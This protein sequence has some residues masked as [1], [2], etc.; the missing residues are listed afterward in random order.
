MTRKTAPTLL[1]LL[2]IPL[3]GWAQVDTSEWLCESCPF[4]DGHRGNYDVG[5]TYVSDDAVRYGNATGYDSEGFYANIDGDG[6][7]SSDGYRANWRIEDLGLDSRVLSMDTGR[8]GVY[9]L[10]LGYSELPYRRFDSTQTIFK[11]SSGVLEL[12]PSWVAAGT[13]GGFTELATS[14]KSQNIESDRQLAEIGGHWF[15]TNAIRVY[16]DYSRQTRDGI[17]I[18]GGPGFSQ[19]ALLPRRIDFATD[20]MDVGIRYLGKNGSLTLA[21]FGS[22]FDNR[23]S[24][25]TWQTPF[26]AAPGAEQLTMAEE[27]DNSY[28]QLSLS[29]AWHADF[30]NTVLA[31]SLAQGQGEQNDALL[32]Y[33][34]N[35]NVV[36][37]ALPVNSLRGQVDT[38]NYAVSIT[39]HPIQRARIRFS[40]RYDERD[41][42]TA[43]NDWS[44][45]IADVFP[46]NDT[47]QNVPYSFKR[48]RLSIAADARILKSV[49]VAAGYERAAMDRDYQ[50]VAEQTEDTG[51]GQVRWRPLNWLDLRAK[52]GA[53]KRDIGRYDEAIAVSLGQN[54]L[55]R[56][57][58][59]ASRY[60]EFG[61]LTAALSP[62]EAPISLTAT[63]YAAED[64]Y[65]ESKLGITNGEEL[66]YTADVSWAI[67]EM[68]STYLLFGSES[69]DAEQLGSAQGGVADWQASHEDSFDHW[70]VGFR[71][72]Q[73][74]GKFDLRLDYSMGDGDT[75][76]EVDDGSPDS[77]F[78]QLLS[79]L[80]SLRFRAAYRWS[81]RM[82][83][84]IDA[85]YESFATDDWA[86]ADVAADTVPTVLTLGAAPYDYDIWAIGVGFRYYFA[87]RDVQLT[88]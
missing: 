75:R 83:L 55:L 24:A 51:W 57:Y 33:T 77:T 45:V 4:E 42:T 76:I 52:G 85:R 49:R 19:S 43:I 86:L 23:N 22:Y 82:D 72:R 74:D 79:T 62:G 60:R 63:V 12:P 17:D 11:Q 88:N 20:Q 29:G 56:K 44:R 34:S 71:W 35:P 73:A 37:A 40:Y 84:T 67:T 81:D 80:D 69:F 25:L 28:Q 50:E 14:L 58:N 3:T 15:A 21:Y 48:E 9:G 1:L 41:N 27:P 64:S 47:E 31:F 78:P 36:T 8:Q 6:A 32:P 46:S 61:E 26:T 39:A 70:G 66:R 38:G 68:A 16:A 30:W 10:H 53:S 18:K 7:Y 54:P 13:T 87:G 5:S 59:L 65:S 2:A